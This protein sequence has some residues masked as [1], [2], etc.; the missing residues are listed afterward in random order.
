MRWLRVVVLRLADLFQKERR[1][2]ELA[3]EI[4]SRLNMHVEDNVRAGLSR[5]A[6]LR[7]AL[8][9][10]G[11]IEALK[12]SHRERRGLPALE[13]L[14]RDLRYALR[15]L[16]RSP[17]FTAVAVSPGPSAS[18]SRNCWRA[19]PVRSDPPSSPATTSGCWHAARAG[20]NHPS[21]G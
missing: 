4:E 14:M 20:A 1:E 10:L 19:A 8:V 11:G 16:R 17:G 3:E 5:E 2:R 7:D 15:G 13:N 18:I 9:K 21:R 12:E 6:A